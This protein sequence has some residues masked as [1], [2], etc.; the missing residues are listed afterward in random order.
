[1]FGL[2]CIGWVV[3]NTYHN[4]F[5]WSLQTLFDFFLR[6]AKPPSRIIICNCCGSD[7]FYVCKQWCAYVAL[8]EILLPIRDGVHDV[9]YM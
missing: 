1:M 6:F 9:A 7:K 8:C 4:G 3:W 5:M 2:C